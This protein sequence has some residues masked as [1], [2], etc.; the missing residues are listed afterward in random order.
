[1]LVV[2]FII[3]LII[4]IVSFFIY[5]W[6][7][8]EWHEIT[9]L[10]FGVTTFVSMIAEP[11]IIIAIICNIVSFSDLNVADKKIVMYEEENKNIQ[12]QIAEIVKNY[13]D[14]EK[15]TYTE[16]LKNI[17]LSNTDVVVLAQLYPDLKSN[18]MVN[19]QIE[20]YQENNKKIKE[21]KEQKINKE[22]SKWWLYFGEI[23]EVKK[24]E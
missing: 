13:Q 7:E 11:F 5:A 4:G 17:E 3:F 16:S 23:E 24:N 12:T 22:I 9:G 19:K 1:M 8:E 14:Y 2:L 6:A 20:I 10:I 21:L 18:E 15:N